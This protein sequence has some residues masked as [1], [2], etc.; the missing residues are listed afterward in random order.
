MSLP[1]TPDP[2]AEPWN[3][4]ASGFNPLQTWDQLVAEIGD[5]TNPHLHE[6]E[7]PPD[8]LESE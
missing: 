8:E 4:D 3:P 7:T 1:E 2:M 6:P 5:P